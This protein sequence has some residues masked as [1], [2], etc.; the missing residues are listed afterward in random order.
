MIE[1][2]ND[3]VAINV[4]NHSFV[5]AIFFAEKALNLSQ[6]KVNQINALTDTDIVL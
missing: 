3:K 6:L 5:D 1:H 4:K 2:L